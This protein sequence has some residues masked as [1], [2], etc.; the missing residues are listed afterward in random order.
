MQRVGL[1]QQAIEL[2]TLEELAQSRDLAAGIGGVGVLG[3]RYPRVLEYRLTRARNRA[4]PEAV[5]AIE[6]R[7]VLS[8]VTSLLMHS[9]RPGWAAIHC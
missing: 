5:C 9:V 1:H 7:R 6:P 4:G 3:D 8:P 2:D